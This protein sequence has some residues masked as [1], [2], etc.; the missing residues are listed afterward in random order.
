MRSKVNLGLHAESKDFKQCISANPHDYTESHLIQVTV[1]FYITTC[2][3][4]LADV[5]CFT[6][7]V[8]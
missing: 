1:L 2:I 8:F 3:T 7:S 6:C 4:L 5:I